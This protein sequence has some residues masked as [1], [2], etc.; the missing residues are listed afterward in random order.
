[1]W[2][3]LVIWL[4]GGFATIG[5]LKGIETVEGTGKIENEVYLLKFIQSWY[6][7]GMLIIILLTEIGNQISKKE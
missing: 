1:M 6:A 2:T 4:A 7:F 3:L 5:G